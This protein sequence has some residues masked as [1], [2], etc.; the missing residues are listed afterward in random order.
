MN[1]AERLSEIETK[2]KRM[3]GRRELN[4]KQFE[5]FCELLT[6]QL[7]IVNPGWREEMTQLVDEL[8]TKNVGPIPRSS[9]D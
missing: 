4:A 9:A 2:L 7:S 3:D 5:Y 1:D 8:R 6:E